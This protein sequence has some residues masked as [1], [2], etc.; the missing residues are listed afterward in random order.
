MNTSSGLNT[1]SLCQHLSS[2]NLVRQEC[3]QHE[4]PEP[5]SRRRY[6][7]RWLKTGR[8]AGKR[9]IKVIVGNQQNLTGALPTETRCVSQNLIPI[10]LSDTSL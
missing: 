7:K 3:L 6:R 1:P 8:C 5:V 4:K 9:H 2:L 10:E